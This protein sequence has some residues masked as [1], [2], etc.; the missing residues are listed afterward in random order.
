[1]H[2]IKQFF[3][4]ITAYFSCYSDEIADRYLNIREK[5]KFMELPKHERAHALNTASII[6]SFNLQRNREVLIKAALLH[7]IGKAGS[8]IGLIKKSVLVLTDKFFPYFSHKLSLKIN[9]FNVYY[10]HPDLGAEILKT[11]GTDERVILL[12]KY[13]H[14]EDNN[15]EGMELLKKADSMN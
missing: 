11:T 5:E 4:G 12:V 1:M 8:S 15:I 3:K 2:R 6:E 13:H 14:S 10:K 7:D 9:M